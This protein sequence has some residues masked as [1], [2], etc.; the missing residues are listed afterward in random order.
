VRRE[1]KDLASFREGLV[2]AVEMAD[3]RGRLRSL[4]NGFGEFG[5][6]P[7]SGAPSSGKFWESG[8]GPCGADD[9]S[10]CGM[11]EIVS[12]CGTVPDEAT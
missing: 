4:S 5:R 11:T 10:S 9:I 1:D 3:D 12:C 6:S 2:E 8:D 7:S